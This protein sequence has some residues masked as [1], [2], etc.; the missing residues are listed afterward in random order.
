MTVI[1]PSAKALVINPLKMSQTLGGAMAFLG[2]DRAMPLLHGS[3]GCTAFGLVLLVRHFREAIPFQT[4]AMNEV[5]TILGGL[6]NLEQACLNIHKRTACRVIGICTTGLIETRG[7]DLEGDIRLIRSRNPDLADV[8]LVPVSTPDFAGALESGWSKAVAAMVDHLVLPSAGRRP[9][10]INILA[11]SHLS[12][13]DIEE[14]REMAEAFGLTP[15]ILPDL[16]LSLDGHIPGQH[17]AT[18]LGGTTLEAIGGMGASC[19]TVAIGRHMAAAAERLHERCA[20]PFTVVE[21][22]VGLPAVDD[23]VRLLQT[24]SGRPAP[25]AIRRSRSQLEDAMLDGHFFFGG[26]RIA[27]AAEP[28]L[29]LALAT[30]CAGLGAQVVSAVT[31][32]PSPSLAGVPA[33]S[34]TIGDMDDLEQQAKAAGAQL[35]I[36][37]S[38]GRMAAERLGIPL[39]RVGFPIFDRLGA[40][41]LRTVGYRGTRD[42]IFAIGNLLIEQ[43]HD[44][45]PGAR[46]DGIG[47]AMREG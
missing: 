26:T 27:L 38:H 9:D 36:T 23:F 24:V 47:P 25:P 28:D 33:P 14:I 32:T 2:L 22:L 18:T 46:A 40:A 16:G 6:D 13:G 37:H 43:A 19:H 45:A 12:P 42:L 29:L 15:V 1:Q 8:A 44:L 3:Q 34:V 41:H 17:V 39:F 5:T 35:L 11:G 10:Q 30:F 31:S 7:E 20:V 4:T 21:G